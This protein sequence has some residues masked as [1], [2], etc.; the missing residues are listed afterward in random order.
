VLEQ[1]PEGVG[2]LLRQRQYSK[3]RTLGQPLRERHL[4]A[5]LGWLNP[6]SAWKVKS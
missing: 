6:N 2:A 5:V 3:E 4:K 1:R